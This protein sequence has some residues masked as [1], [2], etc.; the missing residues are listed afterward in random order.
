MS[1]AAEKGHNA[2]VKA[3][4]K[5]GCDVNKAMNNGTAPLMSA[6]QNRLGEVSEALRKGG[7]DMDKAMNNGATRRYIAA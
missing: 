1:V 7:C 2:M 5:G 6:A 4:I 3:L